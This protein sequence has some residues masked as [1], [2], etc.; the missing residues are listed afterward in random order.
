MTRVIVQQ[1]DGTQTVFNWTDITGEADVRRRVLDAMPGHH[2]E[3][4]SIFVEQV[5]LLRPTPTADILGTALSAEAKRRTAEDELRRFLDDEQQAQVELLHEIFRRDWPRLQTL[6]L[7]GDYNQPAELGPGHYRNQPEKFLERIC[8]SH[9]IVLDGGARISPFEFRVVVNRR[10][11]KNDQFCTHVYVSRHYP[12]KD[13]PGE[14]WHLDLR[15]GNI[16]ELIMG[17]FY[18]MV[19]PYIVETKEE[20]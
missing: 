19:A 4:L 10:Q 20:A 6:R 15:T 13:E 3:F 7:R 16:A 11:T 12:Y 17:E 8:V 9:G 5:G 1:T 14:K 18:K 2:P